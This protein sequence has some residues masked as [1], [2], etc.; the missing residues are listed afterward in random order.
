MTRYFMDLRNGAEELLDLEGQ[1][2][3]SIK[4]LRDAVLFSAR[5]LFSVDVKNGMVDLRCHIDAH[6]DSGLIVHTLAFKDAVEIISETTSS[7]GID[8]FY[9]P[10]N[11]GK[12]WTPA[13][14]NRIRDLFKTST[15]LSTIGLMVGRTTGSI[16][17]QAKQEAASRRI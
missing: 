10:R 12:G 14:L 11:H 15:P 2:F 4:S 8:P 9:A 5:D 3:S 1:E 16:R 13:D 17:N 7:L 6:D